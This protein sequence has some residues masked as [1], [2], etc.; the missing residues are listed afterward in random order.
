MCSA[1]NE[2]HEHAAPICKILWNGSYRTVWTDCPTCGK[3]Q[4][5]RRI[6]S[7]RTRKIGFDLVHYTHV[8]PSDACAVCGARG[9]KVVE[10][11]LRGS[12]GARRG[13]SGACLAGKAACD[14]TCQGRCHGAGVCSCS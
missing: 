4:P 11:K 14:C 6:E 12:A 10:I 8:D 2:T 1:T 9:G 7:K 3:R 13:C 5:V